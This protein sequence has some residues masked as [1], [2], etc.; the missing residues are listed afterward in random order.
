M[1]QLLMALLVSAVSSVAAAQDSPLAWAARLENSYRIVP[2][3]TYLTASNWDAKLDLYVTRTPDKPLPTLIFIHGGGWT[4]GTKE[5]RDLAILPYLDMGMNVVNVEYRLARVAQAPAA[6]E[7]CRCALRWV[8]QHAKE[9]GVDV[10]KIV[11]SGDSAG[12]HLALTTG[13]LPASAGLDRECPGPDNLKVAAIVNWY[14]IS[15]VSELLDGP[16]MKA[17]AVQWLGSASDREQ[18]ARRVSPLTYVRAGLPPVL[19][20]HGDADPT[21]PYTQSVRLH[22]ALTDAGVANEL[23]TIPGGKH[24]FDCCTLAQ[25]TSAYAKIREF[26]TR[27][28]VLDAQKPPSTAQDRQ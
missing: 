4:G 22:K 10:N 27:Q 26:L 19:T 15:D 28:R 5:G 12:G 25:R 8:I 2:N 24:G 20:I 16:N 14:G 21:V 7:D 9:Y 18:I 17:Y 3:V 1:K 6:V 13:M 11:V 23:M